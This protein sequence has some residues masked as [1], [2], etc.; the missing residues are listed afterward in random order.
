M[1]WL[2]LLLAGI[3]EVGW[4]ISLKY[5][6]GFTRIIPMVCYALFGLGAAYFLSLALRSL[7]LTLSYAIWMGIGIVGS[8]LCGILFFKESYSLLQMLFLLM[9]LCGLIGLRVY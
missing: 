3:F 7:P 9:I 4:I 2:Y 5:T 6:N 8:I 1:D